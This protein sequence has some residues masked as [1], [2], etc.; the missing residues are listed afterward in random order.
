MKVIYI[1]LGLF[2]FAHIE[3][4]AQKGDKPPRH[5]RER[6]SQLEK[7]KLIETLEMDEETTLKFFSRKSELQK[8]IDGLAGKADEIIQR[9]ENIIQEEKNTSSEELKSLINEANSIHFQIEKSKSDFI[10]S[11]DDILSTEQVAKLIVFERRFREELRRVLFRDR[12]RKN[13]D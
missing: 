5:M 8:K 9:M 12:K 10:I 13:R 1:L 3:V 11:L 7:I 4:Y 2:L 6:I